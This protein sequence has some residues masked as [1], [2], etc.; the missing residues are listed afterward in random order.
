[1]EEMH[2]WNS[3]SKLVDVAWSKDGKIL[4]VSNQQG[5]LY[6]FYT[7]PSLHEK[8]MSMKLKQG[9]AEISMFS[10][11]TSLIL[12][13]GILLCYSSFHF[14]TSCMNVLKSLFLNNISL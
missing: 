1:M 3:E 11:L 4:S 8:P 12:L 10:F 5:C 13:L 7:L 9:Q 14:N 6:H 2:A